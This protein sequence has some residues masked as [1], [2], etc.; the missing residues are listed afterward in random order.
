MRD[1]HSGI[2]EVVMGRRSQGTRCKSEVLY[3]HLL[4]T[5]SKAQ[6]LITIGLCEGEE[7]LEL[8]RE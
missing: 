7:L 8:G 5:T 3:T 4:L 1:V 6:V 2:F